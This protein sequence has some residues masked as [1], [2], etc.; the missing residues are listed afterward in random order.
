MIYGQHTLLVFWR[1]DLAG[2][3]GMSSIFYALSN[4]RAIE[5]ECNSVPPSRRCDG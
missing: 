5:F 1:L 2:L 3:A 4:V